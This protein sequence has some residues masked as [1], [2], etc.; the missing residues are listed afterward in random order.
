MY[1]VELTYSLK[2]KSGCHVARIEQRRWAQATSVWD[3]RIGKREN[4]RPKYCIK[5]EGNITVKSICLNWTMFACLFLTRQPPVG[6]GLLIHE[7]S[8]S[9]TT[10]HDCLVRLLWTRISSSQRPL[11]DNTQTFMYRWDSNS[12]S[13]QASCYTPTPWTARSLGPA[14]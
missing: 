6:Q 11:P 10:T 9:Y 14:S 13:L 4:G 3:V 1:I 5:V 7:V 8:R 2:W 12:Q